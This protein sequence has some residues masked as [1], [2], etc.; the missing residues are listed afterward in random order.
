MIDALE[1]VESDAGD[2]KIWRVI[3]IRLEELRA[4]GYERRL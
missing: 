4:T 2:G 1:R 3:Q